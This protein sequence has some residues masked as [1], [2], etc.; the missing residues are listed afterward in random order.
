MKPSGKVG[1]EEIQVRRYRIM[2]HVIATTGHI[3]FIVFLVYLLSGR[4]WEGDILANC[5]DPS[6]RCLCKGTFPFICWISECLNATW[7]GK[8]PGMS[9]AI[10]F[11]SRFWV[12]LSFVPAFSGAWIIRS[13]R[14][15]QDVVVGVLSFTYL[16]I[17]LVPDTIPRPFTVL[18]FAI[19]GSGLLVA[20]VFQFVLPR[21]ALAVTLTIY[22]A[23]YFAISEGIIGS[24][25]DR[26]SVYDWVC[27][28]GSRPTDCFPF[29][30][31]E[32]ALVFGAASAAIV[33][34]AIEIVLRK[35]HNNQL[36][37][38]CTPIN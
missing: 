5:H 3:M 38:D 4:R 21:L 20:F 22:V 33:Y 25:A 26:A 8:V 1:P 35:R 34:C 11:Q 14:H 9:E 28:V 13:R 19:A 37:G 24:G 18:H 7:K 23:S 12:G 17:G 16:G 15:K 31:T 36:I 10:V 29:V 30:V 6:G 2:P 32:W 27:L